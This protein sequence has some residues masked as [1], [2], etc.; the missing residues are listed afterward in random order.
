ENCYLDADP[1][2]Q[3]I[4]RTWQMNTQVQAA[5]QLVKERETMD[6]DQEVIDAIM[7]WQKRML[8]RKIA[9]QG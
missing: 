2:F 7:A 4:S 3:H 9:A 1:Y 5:K 6:F 8:A